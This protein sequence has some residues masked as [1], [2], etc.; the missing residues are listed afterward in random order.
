M[1]Y[2]L[3]GIGITAV[4]LF[5]KRI[6]RSRIDDEITELVSTI[7]P[8]N[9]VEIRNAHKSVQTKRYDPMKIVNQADLKSTEYYFLKNK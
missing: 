1:E 2:V 3:A 4:I 9:P 8:L 7:R 5:Y 6:T